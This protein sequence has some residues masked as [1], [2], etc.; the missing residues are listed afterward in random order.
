MILYQATT[1]YF[2]AGFLVD[3]FTIVEAAPIIKWAEGMSLDYFCNWIYKKKN[4][5]KLYKEP[6]KLQDLDYKKHNLVILQMK[7]D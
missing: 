1:D 6:L 2:C 4:V 5:L 7:R 3:K